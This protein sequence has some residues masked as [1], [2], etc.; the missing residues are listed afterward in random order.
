MT[1]LSYLSIYLSI[2]TYL[3]GSGREQFIEALKSSSDNSNG[4]ETKWIIARG[5]YEEIGEIIAEKL[6]S[7]NRVVIDKPNITFNQRKIW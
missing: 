3:K 1:I 4:N 2:Y 5:D 7:N 6:Q